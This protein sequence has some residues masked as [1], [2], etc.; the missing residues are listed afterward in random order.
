MKSCLK[1]LATPKTWDIK[2]KKNVWTMKPKSPHKIDNCMPIATIFKDHLKY[3]KTTKDVKNIVYGKGVLVDNKKVKDIHFGVGVMDVLEIPELKEKYLMIINKKGKLAIIK[4]D[5][6]FKIAKIIGKTRTK[7]KTQ[8]NLFGG[9]NIFVAKDDFKVGDTILVDTKDNSIKEH[10][11][12][13]EGMT[14]ILLGGKH[15]GEFGKIKQ[16]KNNKIVIEGDNKEEFE[17]VKDVVYIVGK[18]KSLIEIK[19]K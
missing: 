5:L 9:S 15:I 2:R 14:C 3:A 4:S 18:E 13:S 6:K 19:E 11:K 1:S 17:T 8:L 12:F 16:I 10:I 7:N